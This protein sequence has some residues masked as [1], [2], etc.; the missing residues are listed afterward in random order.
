M[1]TRSKVLTIPKVFNII[2]RNYNKDVIPDTL[3]WYFKYCT[4]CQDKKIPDCIHCITK[5]IFALNYLKEYGLYTD[6]DNRKF[7]VHTHL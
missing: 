1:K 6:L 3:H 2:E 7:Y 4:P 5:M